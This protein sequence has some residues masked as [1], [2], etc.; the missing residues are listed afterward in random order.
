MSIIIPD[1]KGAVEIKDE[2][3]SKIAGIAASSCYGVVGMSVRN[4]KDGIVHLLKRESMSKGVEIHTFD[5][6]DIAV[7]LHII[8]EYGTNINAIA[9]VVISTVK[10]KLEE[11]L[12]KPVDKVSVVV[13]GVR[14]DG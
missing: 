3:I 10:Y 12:G 14:V 8:V 2:V 5:D 6:N 1:A 7:I 13:E 9:D 4:M 11:S